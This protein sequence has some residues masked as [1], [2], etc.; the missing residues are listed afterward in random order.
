[1]KT[2]F[3]I[4]GLILVSISVLFYS[5]LPDR[6]P[7]APVE[8]QRPV[9]ATFDTVGGSGINVPLNSIITMKFNEQMDLNTFPSNFV[10]ESSGGKVD[11]TFKYGAADTIIQYTPIDNYKPAE[12]YTATLKG[13]VMDIHGNS[14]ISPVKSDEPQS[15]WFFTSGKYSQNGY[16]LVFIRD[17]ADKKIIYRV[18]E[19][20]AY[21]DSLILP[22]AEDYQNSQIAVDPLMDYLYVVDLKTTTGVVSIIN[23][24][25]MSLVNQVQVGFGPTS[26]V[27]SDD[28]AFVTNTFEKSFS[29]ISLNSQS[30]D[31]TVTFSDGFT[32]QGVAYS[33]SSQK[34]FFYSLTLPSIEIVDANNYQ[35][36]H[37][38]INI[39]DKKFLDIQA[40]PDGN[41]IYLTEAKSSKVL[42][43]DASTE[44][45]TDSL[46]FNLNYS[47]SSAMGS[48]AFYLAYY[49][50]TGGQH[51]GGILKIGINSHNV[52][53]QLKWEYD[54]DQIKLTAAGELLYAV[55]PVDTTV[56]I[57][58][59]DQ[60]H[61]ISQA[62]VRGSLNYLAI[63]KKNYQ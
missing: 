8:I 30:L 23:P 20:N 32:P 47:V 44:K 35:D 4:K 61:R 29:V 11:G 6:M 48:D 50:G 53:A 36:A 15:T 25:T 59:A 3:I 56:Q 45:V 37:Q 40:T 24:Q 38:L 18:G 2:T 39:A 21:K 16:P 58:E 14:M 62:K 57:V 28:K 27:F 19:I 22:G 49:S 9:F 17:K 55:T 5:C 41:Q 33:K 43:L 51:N 42:I 13:G 63:T 34:L 10:V 31:Q 7:P 26:I 54:V 52:I 1:M 12:Y 60:L 46:D